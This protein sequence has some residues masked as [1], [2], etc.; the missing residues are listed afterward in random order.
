M[1]KNTKTF[2]DILINKKGYRVIEI[3]GEGKVPNVWCLSYNKLN[4]EQYFLILN[5]KTYS[6]ASMYENIILNNTKNSN[7]YIS[8]FKILILEKE[9]N[10]PIARDT[11]ILNFELKSF[12]LAGELGKENLNDFEEAL[13]EVVTINDR[14]HNVFKESKVTT[15]FIIINIL[16]FLVSLY[17]NL[18]AGAGIVDIDISVLYA[19]GSNTNISILNGE[20][21]RFLTSMFLHGGIVHLGFNMYALYSIGPLVDRVY[22][23]KNFIKIY[24]ISGITASF[25][26]SFNLQ[27]ISIGASGAIF[28]LLGATLIFAYKLRNNIGKG[29]LYNIII[30][31]ITNIFIGITLPN[32]DNSAH[33]VGLLSGMLVSLILYKEQ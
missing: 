17:F 20:Y 27:G 2:M 11:L 18:R 33:I 32:I 15:T 25:I 22:G 31:I 4:V 28:G 1:T 7:G 30:V 13:N 23:F 14:K 3:D 8:I 9:M 5:P 10:I 19:L 12:Q 21:Y 24:L 29:F 16:Y 6:Y 26:T